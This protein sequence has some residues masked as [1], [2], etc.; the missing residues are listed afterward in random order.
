MQDRNINILQTDVKQK[1]SE[2]MYK[3]TMHYKKLTLGSVHYVMTSII[4]YNCMKL[5]C[6]KLLVN[7]SSQYKLLQ[8]LCF[9]RIA[10]QCFFV[11]QLKE[12]EVIL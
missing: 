2:V 3:E 12:I 6:T 7:D 5:N 9:K 4:C 1:Q 11:L 10:N 8:L